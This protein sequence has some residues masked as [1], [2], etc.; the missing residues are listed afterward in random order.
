MQMVKTYMK[1]CST[2]L[3]IRQMQIKTTM[4]Y[5]LIQIG[6]HEKIHKEQMLERVWREGNPSALWWEC[7]VVHPLWR[8]VWRFFTKTKNRAIIQPCNPTPGY[9]YREKHG[10]KIYAPQYIWG[11]YMHPK[12]FSQF[13][14]TLFTIAKT[15]IEIT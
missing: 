14:A 12:T 5:H 4:R 6:Y 13:I 8:T 1:R 11:A 7:T 10:L 15:T 2:L 9:I 3:V